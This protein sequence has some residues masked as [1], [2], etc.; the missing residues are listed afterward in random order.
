MRFHKHGVCGMWYVVWCSLPSARSATN[1]QKETK[2]KARREDSNPL[3]RDMWLVNHQWKRFWFCDVLPTKLRRTR[4]QLCHGYI[5]SS[6]SRAS[7]NKSWRVMRFLKTM[8]CVCVCANSHRTS[9]KISIFA[10]KNKTKRQGPAWR[11]SNPLLRKKCICSFFFFWAMFYH[12][13]TEDPLWSVPHSPLKWWK[14]QLTK[15]KKV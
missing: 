1:K 11:D 4:W 15:Q 8:F 12:W 10:T 3:L 7:N 9:S 14:Q 5:W 2:R 13:T 6:T